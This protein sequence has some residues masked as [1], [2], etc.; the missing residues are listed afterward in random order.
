MKLTISFLFALFFLLSCDG[1]NDDGSNICIKKNCSDF[2]SQAA[3]QA[4]YNA[5]PDCYGNLDG[6]ND[7]IACEHLN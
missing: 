6:D 7:G 4:A 5:D 1:S 2:S 3:A